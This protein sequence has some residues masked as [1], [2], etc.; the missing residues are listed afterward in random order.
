VPSPWELNENKRIAARLNRLRKNHIAK[1]TLNHPAA[2][3]AGLKAS[4]T[5]HLAAVKFFSRA[6]EP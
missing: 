4:T 1:P 6:L 5:R 3:D 2:L